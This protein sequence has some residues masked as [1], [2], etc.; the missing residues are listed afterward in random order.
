VLFPPSNFA[1][2]MAIAETKSPEP[3]APCTTDLRDYC[4]GVASRAQ[5][6]SADLAQVSGATKNAWLKRSAAA[7][8]AR[9]DE[10]QTANARDLAA[11]PPASRAFRPTPC[12]SSTRP[13]AKRSA[14]FSSL[15]S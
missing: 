11:A 4:V 14:S 7:L 13:I 6:A 9:F 3:A 1:P 15:I 5:A 8:R 10:I 2:F 12:N